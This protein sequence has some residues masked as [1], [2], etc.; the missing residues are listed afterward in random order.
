MKKVTFFLTVALGITVSTGISRADSYKYSP[1]MGLDYVFSEFS[2]NSYSPHYNG[3]GIHI[4]SDYSKYFVTE[5]FFNQ[6][7]HDAKSTSLGKLKTSYR[8]YG[9]DLTGYL[10]LDCDQKFS[11]LATIGAGEYIYKITHRPQTR[12]NESGHGYRYGAGF[13]Y[14]FDKHFALKLIGRY[15]KFDKTHLYDHAAEYNASIEYHF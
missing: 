7:N 2:A 13:K 12:H 5:I 4:G 11:L 9:L 1:Y 14:M 15:T 6:S 8:S 10:P 3:A